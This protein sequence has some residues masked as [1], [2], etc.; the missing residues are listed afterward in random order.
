MTHDIGEITAEEPSK[1]RKPI[2][3]RDWNGKRP[4]RPPLNEIL[5][6]R[7]YGKKKYLTT[8]RDVA[9]EVTVNAFDKRGEPIKI[10]T[11]SVQ[12]RKRDIAIFSTLATLGLMSTDQIRRLYWGDKRLA[13]V[14]RRLRTLWK[15]HLLETSSSLRETLEDLDLRPGDIWMLSDTSR[16][17]L[18]AQ[19]EK[20]SKLNPRVYNSARG[21]SLGRHDLVTTEAYI[22]FVTMLRHYQSRVRWRGEQQSIIFNGDKAI[23][24]PDGQFLILPQTSDGVYLEPSRKYRVNGFWEADRRSASD[25][26]YWI[27][28]VQTYQR[29]RQTWVLENP[30]QPF[31]PVFVLFEGAVS[32]YKRALSYLCR[33]TAT[34]NIPF[35]F[36]HFQIATDAYEKTITLLD[37]N[38][39]VPDE[40]IAH[41]LIGQWIHAN[42]T[43]KDAI[44]LA[45]PFESIIVKG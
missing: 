8:L 44:Q 17:V 26:R 25:R 10:T 29:A 16:D 28:K 41:T 33:A 15:N 23:C 32:E 31:P 30:N 5:K 20:P 24:R 6:K 1:F 45:T 9:L 11:P 19:S 34:V 36:K 39:S 13:G 40:L 18:L 21:A 4:V 3:G 14:S 22:Q 27:E 7:G 42:Q 12:I 38:Q 37:N 43:K 2:V 35:Y